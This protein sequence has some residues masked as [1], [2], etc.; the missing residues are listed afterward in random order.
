MC[1][2]SVFSAARAGVAK[3]KAYSAERV[4]HELELLLSIARKLGYSPRDGDRVLDFGCG[5]GRTVEALIAR[6]YDAYGVDV[7]EWWGKDFASYWDDSPIPAET[8]RQRLSCTTEQDYKLPYPDGHFDL[9]ISSQVFE[10]V[11]NYV[12]VFRE[13]GRVMK[14][15]G[16]SVHVFPGRGTPVEPHVFVPIAPLAKRAWWLRLWALVKRRHRPTWQGE[17]E[18]LRDSMRS[19]NYPSRS[20]LHA[21]ARAAGVRLSFR[22]DVYIEAARGSR[23]WKLV[24]L[25]PVLAPLVRRVCQRAMVIT[26]LK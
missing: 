21:F 24:R 2:V 14:R 7:G 13:L 16:V 11:F 3:T 4:D 8:I 22:E 1:D 6:G 20:E 17:F 15:G 18:F 25:A 26:A 23:P 5:M 10:H 19:N 9:I 12:D